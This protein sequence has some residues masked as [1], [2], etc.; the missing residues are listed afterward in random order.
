MDE[1]QQWPSD[2]CDK[3]RFVLVN[4]PWIGR[5]GHG[6][7]TVNLRAAWFYDMRLTSLVPPGFGFQGFCGHFGKSKYPAFCTTVGGALGR[8]TYVNA[9]L[10]SNSDRNPEKIRRT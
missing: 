6:R 7:R 3:T 9:T 2:D 8:Q 1:G 5:K 4:G 10:A